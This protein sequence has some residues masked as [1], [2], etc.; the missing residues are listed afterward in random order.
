VRFKEFSYEV[1]AEVELTFDEADALCELARSHYDGTCK[2]AGKEGGFI[3]GW[4]NQ[5]DVSWRTE[6]DE[7]EP[8][9]VRMSA[10]QIDLCCKILEMAVYLKASYPHYDTLKALQ[11]SLPAL[12]HKVNDEVGRCNVPGTFPAFTAPSE[13]KP[14]LQ[15]LEDLV[16][17]REAGGTIQSAPIMRMYE[18][19]SAQTKA[20]AQKDD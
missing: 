1:Q 6:D 20:W 4:R 12:F 17:F 8:V 7:D 15:M 10:R 13:I 11:K 9:V 2:A 3:Y 16:G 5:T 19:F 14:L 18:G